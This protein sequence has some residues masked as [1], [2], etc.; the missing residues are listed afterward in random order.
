MATAACML[1]FQ[2]DTIH[3]LKLLI[4]CRLLNLFELEV[5]LIQFKIFD[6]K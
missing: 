1:L 5:T 6:P 3:S 4:I 2:W